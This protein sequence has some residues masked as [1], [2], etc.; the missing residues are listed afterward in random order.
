SLFLRSSRSR[1]AC[2]WSRS[3]KRLGLSP[4]N[5]A[6]ASSASYLKVKTWS[7]G[8]AVAAPTGSVVNDRSF[9]RHHRPSCGERARTDGVHNRADLGSGE[10]R[11]L[12]KQ[13]RRELRTLLRGANRAGI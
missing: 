5:P 3:I 6:T 2:A 11:H 9:V 7:R 4:K 10:I 1:S 8:V 13:S 12:S